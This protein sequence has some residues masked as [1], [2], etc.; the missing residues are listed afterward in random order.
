MAHIAPPSP[1]VCGAEAE[2]ISEMHVPFE[3][4]PLHFEIGGLHAV[5]AASRVGTT[6]SIEARIIMT[7]LRDRGRLS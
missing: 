2:T 6:A 7:C 3:R 5:T 4:Q 1:Q